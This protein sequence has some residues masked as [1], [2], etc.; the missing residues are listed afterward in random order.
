MNIKIVCAGKMKESYYTGLA[1]EFAKRIGR[2]CPI[3]LCQTPDE[4]APQALSPAQQ[5]QVMDR[6]GERMLKALRPEEYVIALAVD[7][8]RYT[9]E[10]FSRHL[11]E[12]FDQG[13]S[14]IVFIIGGSLGLSQG[15]L[16]RAEE[17]LSLSD[18]TYPHRIARIVLLEQIYRAFKIARGETYHK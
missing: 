1:E 4:K 14:R 10:A 7:G 13:R 16:E 2:Y 18:M 12:L 3:E 6:E 15:V 5:A 17:T 9:S 11:S 8:R